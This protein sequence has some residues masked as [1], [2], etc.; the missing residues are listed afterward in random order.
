V[1][2]LKRS[3]RGPRT[4]P[5]AYTSGEVAVIKEMQARGLTFFTQREILVEGRRFMVD[6]FVPPNVV[7][8][9]DGP[10]H[11]RSIRASRD[12]VK[13][14]ALKKLGLKVLRFDYSLA[15]SQP[16]RVVDEVLKALKGG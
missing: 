7:V 6:I 1:A 9:I 15:K 3:R 14:G 12:E 5:R 11:L 13:N 16:S 4:S 8:E 10:H 2:A